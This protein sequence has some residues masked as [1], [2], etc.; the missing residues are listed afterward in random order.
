MRVRV[1]HYV[2]LDVEV[3]D[4]RDGTLTLRASRA[5]AAV[6]VPQRPIDIEFEQHGKWSSIHRG[7]IASNDDGLLEIVVER[8]I[9]P[10]PLADTAARAAARR[11]VSVSRWPGPVPG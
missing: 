6:A 10:K 7:H 9:P 3:L 8:C 11:G 4:E 2:E 5:G 1:D